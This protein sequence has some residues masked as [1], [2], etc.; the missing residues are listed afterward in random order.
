MSLSKTLHPRRGNRYAAITGRL[1]WSLWH[2]GL[3]GR[4]AA[5]GAGEPLRAEQGDVDLAAGGAGHSARWAKSA[6]GG[7]QYG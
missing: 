4:R 1:A 5:G 2:F 3:A 7:A 6:A